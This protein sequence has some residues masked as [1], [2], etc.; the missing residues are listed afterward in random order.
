MEARHDILVTK[1]GWIT[2]PGCQRRLKFLRI[3]DETEARHLPIYCRKCRTQ[4]ILDIERGQSVK[5]QSP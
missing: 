1:D 5:R 3:D 4:I 2:C